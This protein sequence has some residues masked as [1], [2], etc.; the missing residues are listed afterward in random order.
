MMKNKSNWK[1]VILTVLLAA[2]G[3]Q[4]AG[5]G[6][7]KTDNTT[8]Q[9]EFVYVPEYR[10]L[11][12]QDG[13][14]QVF[15][16]E[17][18]IYYRSGSYNEAAQSYE[19][20]LVMLKVGEDESQK[21]PLDFG[22]DS[23]I[24]Q[25]AMDRDGSFLAVLSRY[26]YDEGKTGEAGEAAEEEEDAEVLEGTEVSE[27][28][29]VSEGAE[30][31]EDGEASEDAEVPE[32]GEASEDA[33]VPEDGEASEDAKVPEDAET[34]EKKENSKEEL[35]YE[36]VNEGGEGSHVYAGEGVGVAVASSADTGGW[37]EPSSR[38]M[39]LCRFSQDGNILSKTDISDVFED[40][41]SYVQILETDKDGNI[42]MCL[43]QS[44]V[45]LD[46]DGNEICEI[47]TE[48]WI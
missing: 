21:I 27:D 48:D 43:Y 36:I 24:Q 41:E 32:D 44:V 16:N 17:D 9:K 26:V 39:E 34:S 8:A 37:S 19:E 15:I 12:A 29:E 5:C 35:S 4:A 6:G 20:Y 40:E 38:T 46:K 45:V 31:P 18:T 14:D 1:K 23:S 28:V 30:V 10:S 22:E 13:V 47:K 11:D 42:Y 25:I 7:S 33:E 3:I 2:M